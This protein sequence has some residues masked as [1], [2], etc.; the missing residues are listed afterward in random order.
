MANEKRRDRHTTGDWSLDFRK[1]WR[2]FNHAWKAGG[3]R[4]MDYGLLMGVSFLFVPCFG[5]LLFA[6]LEMP[7]LALACVA[8]PFCVGAWALGY[9]HGYKT[10]VRDLRR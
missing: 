4:K 6:Q 9:E 2:E 3:G 8:Y 10:A 5:G 7:L 1:S